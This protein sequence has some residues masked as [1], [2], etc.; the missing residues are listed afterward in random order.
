MPGEN[1]TMRLNARLNECSDSYPKRLAP[2][3][4]SVGSGRMRIREGSTT[5]K[6]PSQSERAVK[7]PD[8]YLRKVDAHRA[9]PDK[10][11]NALIEA[12]LG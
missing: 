3:Q 12:G 7:F 4:D 9:Y 6:Y 1:P 8:E 5:E 10:F 11:V 2:V